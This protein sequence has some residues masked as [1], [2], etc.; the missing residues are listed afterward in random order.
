MKKIVKRAIAYGTIWY[1]KFRPI[2]QTEK[3]VAFLFHVSKWKQPYLSSFLEGYELRFVPFDYKFAFLRYELEKYTN[4]IFMVWGYPQDDELILYAQ[5]HQIAIFRMEDGFVRSKGL[6]SMHTPPYS[7]CIDN[8]GMYFDATQPS[9]LEE[10]LNTYPFQED[11]ILMTEA[12][13]CIKL[14]TKYGISK[15]NHI[16]RKDMAAI[17]GSKTKKRILVIGQVEDDASI[18]KGSFKKWTNND[19]VRI[20]SNENPD[21]EI[22]YKPHPDVMTGRRKNQ[23]NPDDIR[24]LA[25]II[26]EP[27]RLV[28]AL[29][30]IDHVYT[31]TSLSGFEALIRGIPV[32]TLGAPFYSGWGL[33]DD[34]QPVHRRKRKL[35]LL[36]LFAGAYILYP[37]Y[38]DP[39]TK[40]KLTLEETIKRINNHG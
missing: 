37:N 8:R 4:K 15:Y 10:I 22:M 19:L 5:K 36:E 33:T 30:S 18:E 35:S 31:I 38:R 24:H 1:W 7:I 32:T 28:D 26:E 16:Q 3:P 20:A 23:S 34:R 13:R 25:T 29:Q 2:Q 40:E 17:Y 14:L 11:A 39:Y 6:G 21:A 12:V 9:D 27:V